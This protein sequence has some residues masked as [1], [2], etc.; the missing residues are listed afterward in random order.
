MGVMAEEHP[1]GGRQRQ[2]ITG[3]FLPGQMLGTRHELL[4]LDAGELGEGAVM[5]LVTPD[6]LGGR[7]HRVAAI[8]FFVVAVILVTVDDDLVADFPA[9]DLVADGPDD[10]RSIRPCNVVFGLVNVERADRLAEPGPN[11]VVVDAGGHHQDQHLVAI[12]RPGRHDLELHSL[13]R[14]TVALAADRP[15]I[16]VLGDMAERWNLAKLVEIFLFARGPFGDRTGFRYGG[17]RRSP[18]GLVVGRHCASHNTASLAACK[19]L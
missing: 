15:G 11:A 14:R 13:F 12:Q 3:A 19:C 1:I 16:H 5:G 7:E 4:R 17:H 18:C 2:R 9:F 6:A 10:A 8:A